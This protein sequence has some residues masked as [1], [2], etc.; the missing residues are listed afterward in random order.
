MN[1]TTDTNG[2]I[3]SEPACP[4]AD[5]REIDLGEGE[6]TTLDSE[7]VA[8]TAPC[9]RC[10]AWVVVTASNARIGWGEPEDA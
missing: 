9:R 5:D 4:T 3:E 2:D 6:L 1:D 7:L 10:G 8:F